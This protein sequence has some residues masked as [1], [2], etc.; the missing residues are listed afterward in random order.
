[1]SEFSWNQLED[2][3]LLMPSASA[4]A[5]YLND[6]G[7][8]VLRQQGDYG[9]DDEVVIVPFTFAP[10]LVKRLQDLMAIRGQGNAAAANPRVI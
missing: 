9:E 3:E 8:I 6:A 4:V 10:K 5:V 1:M 2:G 7:D